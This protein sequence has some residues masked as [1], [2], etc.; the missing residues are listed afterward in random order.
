VTNSFK[1]EQEEKLEI[2]DLKKFMSSLTSQ[3]FGHVQTI[4]TAYLQG[5]Q[6]NS[7]LKGFVG[8]LMYNC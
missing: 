4:I 2:R 1:N 3:Y 7:V 6:D 8:M 5:A